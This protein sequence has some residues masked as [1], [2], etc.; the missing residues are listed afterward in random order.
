MTDRGL[1]EKEFK[2]IGEPKEW[3]VFMEEPMGA[4]VRMTKDNRNLT[5]EILQS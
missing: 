4:T 5:L 1:N 3:G 2:S